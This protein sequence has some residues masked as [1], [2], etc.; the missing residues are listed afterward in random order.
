MTEQQ[1]S[2]I[3][4]P[5]KTIA[6]N[7]F[8]DI[9]DAKFDDN[10]FCSTAPGADPNITRN[11]IA[12]RLQAHTIFSPITEGEY[13]EE[14]VETDGA[15]VIHSKYGVDLSHDLDSWEVGTE[16]EFVLDGSIR[17]AGMVHNIRAERLGEPNGA[18]YPEVVPKDVFAVNVDE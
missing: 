12:A 18:I 16:D 15:Y 8:G 6:D 1:Q 3:V 4:E 2:P 14:L 13:D 11:V 10:G 9:I 17:L 5:F 7:E